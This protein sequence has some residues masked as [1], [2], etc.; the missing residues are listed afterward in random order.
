MFSG[1][2]NI[3]KNEVLHRILNEWADIIP[4]RFDTYPLVDLAVTKAVLAAQVAGK[5]ATD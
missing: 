2:G 4:A 3:I 5:M 1:V